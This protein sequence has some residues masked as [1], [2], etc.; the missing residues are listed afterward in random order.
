[1]NVEKEAIAQ[2]TCS[3]CGEPCSSQAVQAEEL[4]FCC[5]G[6]KTVYELLADHA[7]CDYYS[8]DTIAPKTPAS[9]ISRKRFEFL[10][11]IQVQQQLLSFTDGRSAALTL[12]IPN[13]QCT[14][15]V[16]LLE[17]LQ[18]IDAGIIQGSVN[19]MKRTL[20][21]RFDPTKTSL[22]AIAE[23]LTTIGYEPDLKLGDLDAK[24]AS[25][26]DRSLWLKLGV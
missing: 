22:K 25:S 18:S 19:F 8:F 21:L 6:C 1:M 2:Q 7:L 16:W 14:S 10:D 11:D 15:C 17:N 12:R 23:L 9:G 13:I 3:H 26:V 24:K 4:T 20:T 5:Q